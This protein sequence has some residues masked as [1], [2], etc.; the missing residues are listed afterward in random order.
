MDFLDRECD[1]CGKIAL[2]N[3]MTGIKGKILCRDCANAVD[4]EVNA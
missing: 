2:L 4:G 1:N 3:E